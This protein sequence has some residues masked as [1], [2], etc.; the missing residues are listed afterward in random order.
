[1][2]LVL[3]SEA[4]WRD[5]KSATTVALP[6]LLRGRWATS[7][8]TELFYIVHIHGR[9][10]ELPMVLC[11]SPCV[12]VVFSHCNRVGSNR[13]LRGLLSGTYFGFWT[14]INNTGH[15]IFCVK[16]V[17]YLT[18]YMM[19]IDIQ[20]VMYEIIGGGGRLRA[21]GAPPP[22]FYSTILRKW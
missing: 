19:R 11:C 14:V 13:V 18:L 17:W 9:V 7:I 8:A 4:W 10:G 5:E 2:Q 15:L 21:P 1:M 20:R 12:C 3:Y 16:K 22:R 6:L